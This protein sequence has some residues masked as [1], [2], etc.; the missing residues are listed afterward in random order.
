MSI[1]P[2]DKT[3]KAEPVVWRCICRALPTSFKT[4]AEFAHNPLELFEKEARLSREFDNWVS[5]NRHRPCAQI[6]FA[7]HTKDD[8]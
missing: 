3:A 4:P 7:T 2:G 6:N 8:N 1:I 5:E